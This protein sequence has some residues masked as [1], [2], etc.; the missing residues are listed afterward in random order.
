[1]YLLGNLGLASFLT[2]IAIWVR[3]QPIESAYLAAPNL[4][5]QAKLERAKE[6]ISFWRTGLL[7][8]LG[9]YLALLVSWFGSVVKMNKELTTDKSELFL[10]HAAGTIY[11]A[12]QSAWYLFGV[13]AEIAGKSRQAIKILEKVPTCPKD[14]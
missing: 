8:A 14:E 12:V 4:L 2:S 7:A 13:L 6:E 5:S 3:Y 9:G 10:L 1:M 11:V